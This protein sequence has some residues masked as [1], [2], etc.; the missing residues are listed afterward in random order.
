LVKQLFRETQ[1]KYSGIRLQ[2]FEGSNGQLSEW[3]ATGRID[4]ALVY[5]YDAVDSAVEKELGF[6]DACLIS[7]AAD[8][9][10]GT[11]TVCF[12]ELA[13]LPLILPSKPNPLRIVLDQIAARMQITLT[14]ALEADSV[15]IQKNMVAEGA[16]YAILGA[17][18]IAREA[19][20]GTLRSSRIVDPFI[21]RNAVLTM[22]TTRPPTLAMRTV[23]TLV[24]Q[25]SR[26]LFDSTR[27]LDKKL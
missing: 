27:P 14:I 20:H 24:E 10:V 22:T 17:P 9:V 5:R 4:I 6:C 1:E 23:A 26:A 18:A 8:T 16:A 7:R 25:F 2:F 3:I 15:P 11:P 19:E 12:R 13:G 21:R